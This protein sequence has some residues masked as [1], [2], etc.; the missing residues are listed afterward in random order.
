MQDIADE[1]VA[2]VKAG[3]AKLSVGRPE[4][5]ADITPVVSEAS[6]NFIQ[7]RAAAAEAAAVA[8]A[9]A[10][11]VLV[12]V[13]HQ[14][15]EESVGTSRDIQSSRGTSCTSGKHGRLFTLQQQG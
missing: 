4:D 5:N 10:V 1:L 9:A 8:A 2:K 7:V 6:A 12:V 15:Q 14:Q 11:V 3:V 13:A